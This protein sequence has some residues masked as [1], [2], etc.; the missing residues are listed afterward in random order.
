MAAMSRIGAALLLLAGFAEAQTKPEPYRL[1]LADPATRQ[2]INCY[3]ATAFAM[4]DAFTFGNADRNI[5]RGPKYL[6]TDLAF[7]KTIPL[8]GRAR[9]QVRADVF[10]LF[11]NVNFGNPNAVFGSANFGRISAA[12]AMRQVQLGARVLF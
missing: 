1:L 4:P 9:V 7:A 3:D 11:N 12:G 10:N 6:Q 2:R 5:L 8:G